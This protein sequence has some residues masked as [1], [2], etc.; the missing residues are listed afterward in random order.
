MNNKLLSIIIPSYNMESYLNRCLDSLILED[1]NKLNKLDI[2]IVNDGSK[3]KTSEIAHSY[4]NKYPNSIKV[5]DKTNGH[6]GSCINA[7]LPVATGKYFRILDADDWFDSNS[8]S[9]LLTE[10]DHTEVDCICTDYSTHEGD[11]VTTNTLSKS[12]INNAE[13]DLHSICLPNDTFAMHRLTYKSDFLRSIKYRQTEKVCYT[14]I[15]YVYYPL[16]RA[17]TFKYIPVS[18]YQYF[19]GRDDQSVSFKSFFNNRN[20][21]IP[22]LSRLL[23]SKEDDTN[24][25]TNGSRILGYVLNLLFS[26][27]LSMQLLVEVPSKETNRIIRSLL[28]NL[29]KFYPNIYKNVTNQKIRFIPFVK[30]WLF[31]D[32]LSLILLFPIR[33]RMKKKL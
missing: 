27:F 33:L 28:E 11:K 5:I 3:D 8:L 17:K 19:I 22:I 26:Y 23:S 1:K 9:F 6:Y 25:N 12:E 10:L 14:D 32:F 15:E 18:L 30:L 16:S 13:I 2:I 24:I 21:Y 4:S 7:A 20:H 31:S 29:K